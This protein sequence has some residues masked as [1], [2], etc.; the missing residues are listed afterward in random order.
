[1]T[2]SLSRMN[3]SS[4]KKSFHLDKAF[5][6]DD[7]D[8]GST[9]LIPPP[10]YKA[11]L[12]IAPGKDGGGLPP[13]PP[14]PYSP[15]KK[16]ST[17]PKKD[18]AAINNNN[19]QPSAHLKK[20]NSPEKAA[21]VKHLAK[22]SEL[23]ETPLTVAVSDA[24]SS[25]PTQEDSD[26]ARINESFE[27][28]ELS[29][30]QIDQ[31]VNEIASA[32]NSPSLPYIQTVKRNVTV[33]CSSGKIP[34]TVRGGAE[35]ALAIV[36]DSV[37]HPDLF[38]LIHSGDILLSVE[39]TEVTGMIL[40]DV[41]ILLQSLLNSTNETEIEVV[42]ESIMPADLR[43][44]L[45]D[46]TWSDMQSVIRDNVYAR[47]VPYTTRPPKPGEVDGEQY[48]FVS[49][50]T[51]VDLQR[52]EM[53]LEQGCFQGHFYGTPRPDDCDD[54][55]SGIVQDDLRACDD[56]A[57][58]ILAFE[59]S[60]MV[61]AMNVLPTPVADSDHE[62]GPLPPNWEVAY[63][64]HGEKYF[65]DHNTGTTQWDDPRDLLP[66]GWERV[67][68]EEYGT[69]YVDHVNKRTQ[70]ERPSF[71]TS[72]GKGPAP[73]PPVNGNGY[74][75]NQVASSS[76][77]YV[78]GNGGSIIN[79]NA[80]NGGTNGWQSSPGQS[81]VHSPPGHQSRQPSTNGIGNQHHT[82]Q[83][84]PPEAIQP[85]T[86]LQPQ[87]RSS[88][89]HR[90]SPRNAMANE[91]TR[92]VNKL[93]GELITARFQK[94]PKGLGFTLIGN[95]ATCTQPEFI[96]I[97]SIIPGGPAALNN[98]L[99]PGD[100]LVYVNNEMMLGAT[101]DDACQIFRRIPVNDYVTLQVCRGYPLLLDPTNKIITENVYAPTTNIHHR[102]REVFT[103]EINKGDRGYGFTLTDTREGQRVKSIIHPN[104]CPN[105]MEG[106]I[107]LEVDGQNVRFLPHDEVI[108]LLQS[109][110]RGFRT[111]M[112]VSRNSPRHRSR[113]P[114]AAF[115]Y[116]EQ[117]AT[118]VPILQPRSK[119]PAPVPVRPNKGSVARQYQPKPP[120]LVK[121]EDRADI[122]ENT[123]RLRPSST[124]LGFASTPNYVPI[125]AFAHDKPQG[126]Q[127][128]TVNL[129]K[130]VGGF[131]FRLQGGQ[132]TNMPL[133]VGQVVPGGAADLDGRLKPNDQIIEIDGQS[134]EYLTHEEVVEKI[135]KAADVGHVKIV[136]RRIREDLPRS[137][138]LPFAYNYGSPQPVKT[139]GDFPQIP[140]VTAHLAQ[141]GGTYNV[142]L[143]KLDSEDFGCTIVSKNHRYIGQVVPDSPADRCGQLHAG[144]CVIAINGCP[145]YNMSH[146]QVINYVKSSGNTI[147]FTI[148]P[149]KRLPAA[150]LHMET[151]RNEHQPAFRNGTATPS[152]IYSELP[153]RR[154][155]STYGQANGHQMDYAE[156]GSL[157][158]VEL[159]RGI[160]G[161]GF[162][163]R[164]G[165]EFEQM[166]LRILKIAEDGPAAANG[167]LRVGDLLI[168][169]NGERTLR[170]THERAIQLI[171]EQQVVRLLVQRPI[172]YLREAAAGYS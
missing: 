83:H 38:N 58:E 118:P 39:K 96:Q 69:F 59:P 65:I 31:A 62:Q 135:R 42:P 55:S 160:K 137:T 32:A 10:E 6:N 116:G 20:W 70:Y 28:I 91:F 117:R 41:H 107:I 156:L 155:S 144:D 97:K 86:T 26:D 136:V 145:L 54:Y 29:R 76:G 36:I 167:N 120:T 132:D 112:L 104:Q 79:G 19:S 119:T 49:I 17:S 23:I 159:P 52:N 98:K 11:D 161:F 35:K 33:P 102:P 67:Y 109:H 105:L 127:L 164:G 12:V 66:E 150:Y 22:S 169:I 94:G 90:V 50:E 77:Q 9:V 75:H 165:W 95:D 80:Q 129:I 168:E 63:S 106:D 146:Q 24:T 84:A 34:F 151:A 16:K 138:S 57:S 51:F 157:I 171:K 61:N 108:S 115:R 101:Q 89:R 172:S 43:T 154:S 1:M 30:L 123:H 140:T 139:L 18:F 125:S 148:D 64:E 131:G 166:P 48:K 4:P 121:S 7:D 113:T 60:E 110:P 27:Q 124:T 72:N 100:V 13:K 99:H 85:A 37:L 103:V 92:D 44:L 14:R 45:A 25:S 3:T 122:Y 74:H 141:A 153:H 56:I 5:I 149:T 87:N 40:R 162:S 133:Y 128:I 53:L 142:D 114:T 21:P 130:K 93:Q 81:H 2:T 170:M 152:N 46:K 8:D 71:G 68:D 126:Q 47:T 82:H 111:S 73:A 134:V 158:Q 78:N 147:C 15:V 163:I 143:A 88:Q